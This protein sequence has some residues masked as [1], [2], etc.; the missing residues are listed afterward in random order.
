[1]VS[2]PERYA[3][4][5][6]GV[7]SCYDRIVITG[8]LPQICYS[9]GM[10]SYLYAQG[11][12]IFNYA[13]FAEPFRTRL[14]ENAEAL[15]KANSMTI[16]FVRKHTISKE[17]IIKKVLKKRGTAPGLVHILSAMESCESY[18]PWHDKKTGKTFLKPKSGKCL[19]YY[20]YFI[21]ED[22]GLCY[23]RVPTWCPFR[24]QIYFN[25]HNLLASKLE[26]RGIGFTMVDNAFDSIEDYDQAQQL[27]DDFDIEKLHSKLDSFAQQ[28]CPVHAC[29][30]QVYHWSVMQAEY[31]TDI[32]FKKQAELQAI[33]DPL[34]RT[35]IHTVKPDNIAT[36]LGRKLTGN[37][38]GEAG[39]HYHVRLEGTRLK[40]S[41]G[42]VSIKM[43]DKFQKILRIETTANDLSFFKHYR[44]V[45]HRNGT[46]SKKYATM[47][48]N[49]YSLAPLRE[50]L[51]ASNRRY[52]QFISAFA[53]H[54]SGRAKL[55]HLSQ[56]LQK[57]N[58]RY[59]GFNFFDQDDLNLLLAIVRG[60]F[61]ISGFRNKD[62]RKYFPGK[63]CGQVSR[64][65]KR[66][67]EYGLIRKAKNAYKYY[68]TK[69]GKQIIVTALKIKELFI[70]PELALVPVES[71][72]LP[73]NGKI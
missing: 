44:T 52:L 56:S 5:I 69:L 13:R 32:V 46:S 8:T 7:L 37:F 25:G 6:A 35:A 2:F 36:F 38:Q 3:D 39:N 47:K 23:V 4:K 42:K 41:M 55:K 62:I 28:Y 50:L 53:D 66:L 64:L 67:R 40:H 19:H 63:N 17:N 29:F 58:R 43:Y 16:E 72:F 14:R 54:S 9:Q 65:I 15:A 59:K 68:A 22:L 10:T 60:E 1:M 51:V 11:V 12:R 24:L 18:T 31:A 26:K 33:Y 34:I 45:E 20:F 73:K 49:I 30:N 61:T 70:I 71:N 48:K 21:D 27:S 57:N